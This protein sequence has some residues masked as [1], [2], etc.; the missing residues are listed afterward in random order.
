MSLVESLK[1]QKK[2][3]SEVKMFCCMQT[4]ACMHHE[5]SNEKRSRVDASMER[6]CKGVVFAK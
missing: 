6:L 3:R 2:Q 5:V 4:H 1:G